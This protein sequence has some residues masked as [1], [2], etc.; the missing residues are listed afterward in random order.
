MPEALVLVDLDDDDDVVD[1]VP[2]PEYIGAAAH[3]I[4]DLDAAENFCQGAEETTAPPVQPSDRRE[5]RNEKDAKAEAVGDTAAEEPK[6]ADQPASTS[7]RWSLLRNV[8]RATR[9]DEYKKKL[10]IDPYVC[11]EIKGEEKRKSVFGFFSSRLGVMP[12]RNTEF[13]RRHETLP[14]EDGG[15]HPRWGPTTN[16]CDTMKVDGLQNPKL[17]IEVKDSDVGMDELIGSAVFDL[18][19][20]LQ[21]P[22]GPARA[23]K[24]ALANV[25]KHVTHA[26]ILTIELARVRHEDGAA[27]VFVRILRAEHLFARQLFAEPFFRSN[28]LHCTGTARILIPAECSAVS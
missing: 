12:K 11:V 13:D 3:E 5:F 15:V 17:H 20:L 23:E 14:C 4:V 19:P 9:S 22:A 6:D 27:A 2:A 18:A 21:R 8:F 26:G 28:A 7:S 25:D 16:W 24:I 10:Q 1:S